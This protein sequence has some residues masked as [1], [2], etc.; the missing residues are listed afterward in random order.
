MNKA[1]VA[2]AAALAATSLS[3]AGGVTPNANGYLVLP[4]APVLEQAQTQGVLD[5][6][7][8][9]FGAGPSAAAGTEIKVMSWARPGDLR[10]WGIPTPRMA[11][12]RP[13]SLTPEQTC[14]LALRY[15][16]ESLVAQARRHGAKAVVDVVSYN[17][18]VVLDSPTSFECIP[19]RASSVVNLKGRIAAQ[20]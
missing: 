6:M 16:L 1:L 13:V 17:D 11:D 2:L 15:T 12:G 9:R 8:V 5:G 3:L 10:G 18:E 20:P 4:L 19:G 14:Q 7:P